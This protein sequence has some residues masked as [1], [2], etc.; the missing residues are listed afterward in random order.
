MARN[1]ALMFVCGLIEYIGRDRKLKRGDV[2]RALG[3]GAIGRIYRH[4]DVLHSEPIEHVAAEYI[5]LAGVSEGVFDNVGGCRYE[6]PGYWTI[7]EVYERLVEDV[8]GDNPVEGVIE[9]YT[10]WIDD[11]ISNYNSDF[12]YQPRD[13]LR[14]CY[15]AGEPI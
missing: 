10:S 7:G 14:E 3:E 2:V 12:F 13:Y 4:A 15:L 11:A 5:A 6:V 1:S 9:V 8:R